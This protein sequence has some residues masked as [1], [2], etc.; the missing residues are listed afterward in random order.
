M[1]SWHMP[2]M[3]L[4]LMLCSSRYR[5]PYILKQE[6]SRALVHRADD[7]QV[8]LLKSFQDVPGCLQAQ[9]EKCCFIV[10]YLLFH[11]LAYLQDHLAI[12]HLSKHKN[13]YK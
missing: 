5:S 2:V 9:F 11:P 7:G 3:G 4:H 10:L 12:N 13:T 1:A 6:N 8:W